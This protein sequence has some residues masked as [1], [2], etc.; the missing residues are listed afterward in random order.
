MRSWSA[1]APGEAGGDPLLA[2][3]DHPIAHADQFGQLRRDQDDGRPF[4]GQLGDHR[5]DLGPDW[6]S[7]P[8]VGSSRIRIRGLVASHLD[9]TTFCWFLP[10]RVL[11]AGRARELQ[12]EPFEMRLDQRELTAAHHQPGHGR[13]AD[14]RHGRIGENGKIHDQAL[15]EPV[16]RDVGD[17]RGHGFAR[18]GE[19]HG[20]PR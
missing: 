11:T 12:P 6:T 8:W 14:Y 17:A 10:D 19:G 18:I 5:M 7:M 1:S 9:S 20:L 16:L 2:Q 13:P 4:A 15:A 3:H